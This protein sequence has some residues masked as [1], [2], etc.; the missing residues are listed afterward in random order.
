MRYRV[1]TKEPIRIVGVRVALQEDAEENFDI[2]PAF[3]DTILKSDL[4]SKIC[5]LSN[6]PPHGILGVSAYRNP[7]DIYYYIAAATD[8]PVSEEMVE[9]EIPATT[10]VIFECDGHYPESVQTIYKR[11]FTEWLPFSGYECAEL[12]DIEVYPISNQ[13]LKGGHSEVWI[14]IKKEK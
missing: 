1:E 7:K 8:E 4:F 10:W 6:Q 5:K 14:A 2:A 12:P 9:F 11:F 3:W 13:K